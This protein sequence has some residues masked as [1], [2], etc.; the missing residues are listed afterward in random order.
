MGKAK[1]VLFKSSKN[2][3]WYFSMLAPN[4]QPIAVSEGYKYKQGAKRAIKAIQ[5]YAP[6]AEVVE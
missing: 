1:F 5:K 4:G 6:T 3:Q 2:N